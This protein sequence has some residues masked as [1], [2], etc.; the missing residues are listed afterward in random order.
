MFKSYAELL[1]SIKEYDVALKFVPRKV[2]NLARN[3]IS[4]KTMDSRI[5]YLLSRHFEFHHVHIF[6]IVVYRSICPSLDS[7]FQCLNLKGKFVV[8]R[9][10][11]CKTK[12]K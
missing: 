2:I 8:F 5:I 10:G 1:C 11:L 12:K 3:D 9:I 6:C 4:V 7:T